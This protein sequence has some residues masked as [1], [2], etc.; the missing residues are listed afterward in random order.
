M[1]EKQKTIKKAVSVSGIG[2]HSG[3][4][5]T[6]TFKPAPANHGYKFKRV[7]LNNQPEIKVDVD[8]VKDTSRGTSIEHN[9]VQVFTTEHVLAAVAGLE[10]DNILIELDQAETPI[11]DG[12]SRYFIEALLQAGIEELDANKE[13]LEISSGITYKDPANKTKIVAEPDPGFSASVRIDYETK[14]LGIQDAEIKSISS[15]EKELSKCRTFVFL[16]ELE[17][18]YENNL[19]KGGDLNNAI[20]F[21]NRVITQEELDRLAKLLNKPKV[22]VLREGI[23]NNLKLHFANEPA[24]HKLLDLIGDLALLGKPIKG[25]IYAHRPGH[26]SNVEFAKKIKEH[27]KNNNKM[28][29]F[30]QYDPNKEPILD[31]NDIKRLLPHRPP[32]LFVDKILEMDDKH[33]V[34]LKNITMNESF[35]VGHFPDEP[36][37]PGVLQIEAMAQCGGVL[38]LSSFPDPQ[39]YTT[40]FLKIENVKFRKKVTPGDTIIFYLSLLSPIRRGIA[41]MKG[42]AYVGDKVVMEAQMMAS[43]RKKEENQKN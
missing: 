43:I 28:K 27:I 18:L 26:Y 1:P 37:M 30:Y 29:E 25:K 13:Y 34:G 40:Y 24:R 36:V 38:V 41:Y 12:S 7:D 33:I 8:Y 19:I 23:L 5:V 42:K 3:K 35:F 14:V 39:N 15:F 22:R 32:F 31:I 17:Y 4:E 16:H 20:V 10:I 2:L 9:G 11:K 21:V 6:L